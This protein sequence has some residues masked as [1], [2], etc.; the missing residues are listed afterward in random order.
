[1][2]SFYASND[3][4]TPEKSYIKAID[5]GRLTQDDR[6]L[7]VHP[8]ATEKYKQQRLCSVVTTQ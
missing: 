4:Y 7:I 8:R 1:M 2:A 6:A 5:E 3:R